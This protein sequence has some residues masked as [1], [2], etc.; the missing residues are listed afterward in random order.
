MQ[1]VTA[2]TKLKDACSL[3][4]KA[5]TNLDSILKS[6]DI[7]WPTKV[8]I[9]KAV[10]FPIVVYGCDSWTRKKV[11]CPKIDAFKLWC[12][13]RVSRVPWTARL[14]N[15][16]IL[17]EINSEYS[18]EG[19]KLKLQYSGHLMRRGDLLEKLRWW[20]RLR[21]GGEEVN[22]GSNGWMASSTQWVWANFRRQ[23]RTGKHGV[24]QSMESQRV[25][26]NRVTNSTLP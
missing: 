14:S 2:A 6:R 11:E 16:S 17:K 3:E 5:M 10:V 12:W 8:H 21:V 13:R 24:L 20:K 23:W 4:K 26:H 7:I 19:L 18:L 15:Q 25:E 9:G 22:R 1:M